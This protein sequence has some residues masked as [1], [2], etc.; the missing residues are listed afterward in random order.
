MERME[1]ESF[2]LQ[3]EAQDQLDEDRNDEILAR[4]EAVEAEAACAKEADR[5]QSMAEGPAKEAA[6]RRL[7]EHQA[8]AQEMRDH[9]E[10]CKARLDKKVATEDPNPKPKPNRNWIGW[11]RNQQ[12]KLIWPT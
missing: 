2:R 11:T 4:V 7:H 1:Q 6:Q 12:L 9:A 8:K 3:S 5:I 10:R